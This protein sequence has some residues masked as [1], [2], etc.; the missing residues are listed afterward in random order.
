V[1]APTS[2]LAASLISLALAADPSQAAGATADCG[3]PAEDSPAVVLAADGF[4]LAEPEGP[5]IVLAGIAFPQADAEHRDPAMTAAYRD[6]AAAGA[7]SVVETGQPDRYGRIVGMVF[8]RNGRLLQAELIRSGRA[9]VRPGSD[10]HACSE[11]LLALE[12]AARR[13]GVGLWGDSKIVAK[14]T[15]RTSLLARSGLYAVVEGRIVSVGYGSR[16]VFLDFGRN[17]RRDFTIMVPE[18]LHPR[19]REAGFPVDSLEGRAVRVRG[20]IEESGGPAIRLTHPLSLEVLD[21]T[22]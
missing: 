22:E 9:I 1:S 3:T 8:A 17:Y 4:H 13:D 18:S 11:A 19:L 6:F 5:E 15:D 7:T 21:L 10:D 20:V 16:M 2:L 14:A 12:A